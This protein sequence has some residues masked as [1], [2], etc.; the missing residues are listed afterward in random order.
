VDC[1]NRKNRETIK[2]KKTENTKVTG[3]KAT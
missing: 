1:R 2:N 3:E